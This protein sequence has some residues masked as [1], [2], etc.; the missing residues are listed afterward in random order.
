[1]KSLS[2]IFSQFPLY[3]REYSRLNLRSNPCHVLRVVEKRPLVA[4]TP[5]KI[6]PI[7]LTIVECLSTQRDLE[8]LGQKSPSNFILGE[9]GGFFRYSPEY[10][11][12][13]QVGSACLQYS[14]WISPCFFLEWV[15]L[16]WASHWSDS[17]T[18]SVSMEIFRSSRQRL[19]M[20]HFKI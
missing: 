19:Q 4:A 16:S 5:K 20:C 1:M 6:V 14:F 9:S 12:G 8:S 18:C 3:E 11:A 7:S 13:W 15:T 2:S 17:M 10:G